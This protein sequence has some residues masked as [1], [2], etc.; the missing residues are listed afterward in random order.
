MARLLWR[1]Q[2]MYGLQVVRP[3]SESTPSPDFCSSRLRSCSS[4]LAHSCHPEEW[5][6]SLA[7]ASRRRIYALGLM[8]SES[9]R[10]A[11]RAFE[12]VSRTAVASATV[13]AMSAAASATAAMPPPSA[14]TSGSSTTSSAVTTTITAS[15][16]SISADRLD[17]IA[18][19][20]GFWFLFEI[21]AAL[22]YGRGS[23]CRRTL[24]LWSRFSAA[25]LCAL[26][27]EDRFARQPN[28]VAFNR[29]HF[30]S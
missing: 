27:F 14:A 1:V 10:L 17:F 7:T 19:K 20:V 12:L 16:S 15:V 18:I 4:L 28:P 2:R 13:T 30:T 6:W 21:A 25:H 3:K 29:Q 5:R 24:T 26:L 23:G 22:D 8:K 9:P 11:S